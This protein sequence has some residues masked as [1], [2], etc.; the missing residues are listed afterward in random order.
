MEF[1]SQKIMCNALDTAWPSSPSS[2]SPYE[3]M[4]LLK[5]HFASPGL[6]WPDLA[7][8]ITITAGV[9]AWVLGDFTEIIA[10]SSI[11]TNFHIHNICIEAASADDNYQLELYHGASNTLLGKLRLTRDSKFNGTVNHDFYGFE[12]PAND[13]I[14]A[15]LA[16]GAGSNTITLSLHYHIRI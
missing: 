2:N 5:C 4:K 9:G 16:S 7:T 10:A 11:A 8:G 1:S 15:K 3:V 13:R 12:V 14:Q 6:I